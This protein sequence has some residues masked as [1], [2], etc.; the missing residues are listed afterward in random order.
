MLAALCTNVPN[1][2]AAIALEVH[3]TPPSP[4]A[5]IGCTVTSPV[6]H[7][8]IAALAA[9][10]RSCPQIAQ[11][12]ILVLRSLHRFFFEEQPWGRRVSQH[13]RSARPLGLSAFAISFQDG[14]RSSTV[15]IRLPL[16]TSWRVTCHR[17][18]WRGPASGDGRLAAGFEF[19]VGEGTLWTRRRQVLASPT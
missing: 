19:L 4:A 1:N 16:W 2:S 11:A 3:T 10:G 9:P 15:V 7:K 6:I 8:P 13:P 5:N 18:S 14:L 12:L 17:R